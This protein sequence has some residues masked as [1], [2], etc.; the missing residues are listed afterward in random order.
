[1]IL[2]PL[3]GR[4]CEAVLKSGSEKALQSFFKRYPN[5]DTICNATAS[6]GVVVDSDDTNLDGPNP[7]DSS[8][9]PGGGTPGGT[10]NGINNGHDNLDQGAPGNSESHNNAENSGNTGQGNSGSGGGWTLVLTTTSQWLDYDNPT[11]EDRPENL[12][13]LSF[14]WFGFCRAGRDCQMNQR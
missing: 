10:S 6:T 4:E 7:G 11:N 14:F 9:T 3:R 1:M 13:G 5:A 8:G 12:P 2:L